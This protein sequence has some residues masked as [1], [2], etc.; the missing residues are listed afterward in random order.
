MTPDQLRELL[1]PKMPDG[2]IVLTTGPLLGLG[3]HSVFSTLSERFAKMGRTVYLD[4]DNATSN[5]E[6]GELLWS[7]NPH[8]AGLS[9]RKPNA[10]YVRQGLFYK[11]ANQLPGYRSIEAMERA[12]G[13]PPPYSIAPKVYYK[14]RKFHLDLSKTVLIDF[15]S[16][17]S[18]IGKRGLQEAI[19]AMNW[20]FKNDIAP[21]TP[22]LQILL[23]KA[24]VLHAPQISAQSYQV[25]SIYEYLD[26]LHACR[27][28]I[29]SE[30]GGQALAAAVRGEHDVYDETARPEIICTI[31]PPTF[32]SRAYT[33]RGVDYRVT[34]DCDNTRDYWQPVE[35]LTMDYEDRC[36]MRGIEFAERACSRA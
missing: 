1:E 18:K 11:I 12:H 23:S 8:I 22:M 30:A 29:G 9:D 7:R 19:D 26:M 32:N 24:V 3:D 36:K 6:I 27:G 34:S 28:W 13:L 16:V 14:P 25:S 2:D 17:S 4:K 20:R 31:V 15:S 10:G 35:R 21:E 5:P 33:F